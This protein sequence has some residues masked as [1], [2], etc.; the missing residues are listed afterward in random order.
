[1][2]T[3]ARRRSIATAAGFTIGVI[4]GDI[5]GLGIRSDNLPFFVALG[6]VIGLGIGLAIGFALDRGHVAVGQE[7]TENRQ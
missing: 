3:I 6:A 5:V 7:K 2:G 1:M 4:L